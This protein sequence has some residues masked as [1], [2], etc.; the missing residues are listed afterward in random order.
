[1]GFWDGLPFPLPIEPQNSSTA[2][3]GSCE[4]NPMTA[5]KDEAPDKSDRRPRR[6]PG[7]PP[8]PALRA[9]CLN[10]CGNLAH[11]GPCPPKDET[12][13]PV[14]LQTGGMHWTVPH[15]HKGGRMVVLVQSRSGCCGHKISADSR[16]SN[17]PTPGFS[18]LNLNRSHRS[19]CQLV[20]ISKVQRSQ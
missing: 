9:Y 10:G 20:A 15:L 11:G 3:L 6:S 8:R 5:P 4:R 2:C 18:V 12:R 19:P 7:S 13:C 17:P 14:C 16:G 1:M